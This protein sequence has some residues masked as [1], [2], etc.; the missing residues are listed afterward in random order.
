MTVGPSVAV[1]A[2]FVNHFFMLQLFVVKLEWGIPG[3]AISMTCSYLVSFAVM[4]IYEKFIVP[5]DHPIHK[6]KIFPKKEELLP[7]DLLKQLKFGLNCTL[8]VIF[9]LGAFEL[10]ILMS[11]YL[12]PVKSTALVISLQIENIVWASAFGISVAAVS[13]IGF[14]IGAGNHVKAKEIAVLI[15]HQTLVIT[16]VTCLLIYFYNQQVVGA[17]TD[18]GVIREE[19]SGVSLSLVLMIFFD[20][21]I[22]V[23]FGIFKAL[24]K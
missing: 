17:Y 1:A 18:N 3:T 8:P 11:A 24:A 10:M 9:G 4:L 7:K 21:L 2:S 15:M 16:S 19:F 23:M 20:F 6:M 5:K 12:G 13:L 22:T 14:E